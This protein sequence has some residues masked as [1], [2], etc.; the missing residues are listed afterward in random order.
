MS[1]RETP[2]IL[3]PST[4][5]AALVGAALV[6]LCFTGPSWAQNPSGAPAAPPDL[7]SRTVPLT[8][9][10][11][12]NV[13]RL[14]ADVRQDPGDPLKLAQYG[15]VLTKIGRTD[16]GLA[17]LTRASGLAPDE[18]KVQLYV[19]R[20]LW[21]ARQDDEALDAAN[22][23]AS[24]PLATNHEAAEAFGLIG[25]IRFSEGRTRDAET[26]FREGIKREPNNGPLYLNLGLM[27]R[28]VRGRMGEG[29]ALV[30]EAVQKSPTDLQ[31]LD[32]AASIMYGVGRLDREKQLRE[33]IADLRPDDPALAGQAATVEWRAGEYEKAA[34][35]L[36]HALKIKPDDPGGRLMY[37]QT[38]LRM[39]RYDDAR[40]EAELAQKLGVV[41]AAATLQAIELERRQAGK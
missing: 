7:R 17:A 40:R 33:Q 28:G 5:A 19:A 21:K 22:K 6:C 25:Y 18:P 8:D 20:G 29:L 38:L 14:A 12:E 27:L 1:R 23:V 4:R 34:Q 32:R 37:A 24:S 13:D 3:A 39:G 15:W 2:D 26:A 35:R 10:V 36:E 9:E 41:E 16:E 31:V 11:K 30:E